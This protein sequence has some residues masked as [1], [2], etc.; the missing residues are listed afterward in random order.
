MIGRLHGDAPGVYLETPGRH[1][2]P[3]CTD[4]VFRH[5]LDWS[6][7]LRASLRLVEPI[8]SAEKIYTPPEDAEDR[9]F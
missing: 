5:R 6:M 8:T 4:F 1:A 3:W 7:M 9:D 2:G